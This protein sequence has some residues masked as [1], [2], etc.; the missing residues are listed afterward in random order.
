MG[1]HSEF[2]KAVKLVVENVTFDNDSI[3]QV[4]EATIRVIG[5]LLSAHLM[6]VDKAQPFGS[7]KPIWYTNQLL[8]LAEDLAS[9]LLPALEQS[10]GLPY[11]RVHLREGVPN[12]TLCSWCKTETCP[13]GAG[14]LLI[15]FGIL[16]RLLNDP[17]Y[18]IAAEKAVQRLWATRD[19]ATGLFGNA[20]DSQ[21]GEWIGD[22]AGV[23]AGVDSFYEYLLKSWILFGKRS[24]WNMFQESYFKIKKYM[25]RGRPHC[26]SGLGQHPVYV[27]VN[28]YSGR[29]STNWIDSLAA[30]WSA[31]QLLAGD[32]E[33]AICTHMLYFSIWL[34]FG[35]LPERFNWQASATDV[36]FYPLR[37]ELAETTY[38]L[39]QATKNPFYL[40]VG[41]NM[42]LSI[43]KY[44]RSE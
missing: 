12:S 24:H 27:N 23:G 43:N 44:T 20:I 18:E 30:S 15:E 36:A 17:R 32:I 4:F 16:S 9:R 10:T 7:I 41:R 33:E 13:A 11:P 35:L 8:K 34:K 14:S 40:H 37:P 42:L 38:L 31:V 5:G 3:V 21:S 19:P 25:R 22:I 39:Y 28:M 1:N 6:I 29:T 2:K 26:N